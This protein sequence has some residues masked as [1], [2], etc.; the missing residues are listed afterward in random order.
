MCVITKEQ[1]LVIKKTS[2]VGIL[3][4]RRTRYRN[5]EEDSFV[6]RK[7]MV[8]QLPN[9]FILIQFHYS[10]QLIYGTIYKYQ[11]EDIKEKN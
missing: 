9:Q 11:Y 6:R 3:W 2:R 10:Y 4:R 5:K 7:P 8:C 1:G